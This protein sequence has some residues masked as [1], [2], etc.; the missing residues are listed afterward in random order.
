MAFV[1]GERISGSV[2]PSASLSSPASMIADSPSQWGYL[3]ED[4][5]AA[6]T[7]QAEAA[8]AVAKKRAV[9]NKPNVG[10][11]NDDEQPP[12]RDISSRPNGS[13]RPV[14]IADVTF[15]SPLHGYR[16]TAKAAHASSSDGPIVVDAGDSRSLYLRLLNDLTGGKSTALACS[17]GAV[18]TS[19]PSPFTPQFL[20]SHASPDH[21]LSQWL[22]TE[23]HRQRTE[24]HPLKLA[25]TDPAAYLPPPEPEYAPTAFGSSDQA[26]TAGGWAAVDEE[27]RDT[28]SDVEE[29][30]QRYWALEQAVIACIRLQCTPSSRVLA[31]DVLPF[32]LPLSQPCLWELCLRF[33]SHLGLQISRS[34]APAFLSST[35]ATASSGLSSR[36]LTSHWEAAF[37]EGSKG[38]L[39]PPPAGTGPA[40][41]DANSMGNC[42]SIAAGAVTPTNAPFLLRVLHRCITVFASNHSQQAVLRQALVQ[43]ETAVA[44]SVPSE[45]TIAAARQLSS[46]LAASQ[47]PMQADA[48]AATLSSALAKAWQAVT[49]PAANADKAA[50]TA[51]KLRACVNRLEPALLTMIR[52]SAVASDV[53]AMTVAASARKVLAS[54]AGAAMSVVTRVASDWVSRVQQ[55]RA[56]EASGSALLLPTAIDSAFASA[57]HA[58]SSDATS[59]SYSTPFFRM[60]SGDAACE[61]GSPIALALSACAA[62]LHS[63]TSS[64]SSSSSYSGCD[65]QPALQVLASSLRLFL[66]LTRALVVAQLRVAG[67]YTAADG[68]AGDYDDDEE[69]DAAAADLNHYLSRLQQ[70]SSLSPSGA[71][72]TG[73]SFSFARLV[74]RQSSA[75]AASTTDVTGNDSHA[76]VCP[77]SAP[78]CDALGLP[79]D[80]LAD[81][82]A[83]VI[84]TA[85]GCGRLIDQLMSCAELLCAFR[86]R[87]LQL[88]SCLYP[89]RSP[90]RLLRAARQVLLALFPGHPTAAIDILLPPPAP[91]T[92]GLQYNSYLNRSIFVG[93]TASS[94]G[95]SSDSVSSFSSSS[96]DLQGSALVSALSSHLGCDAP[97]SLQ[98]AQLTAALRSAGSQARISNNS[99]SSIWGGGGD[100]VTA[101]SMVERAAT[102]VL[103]GDHVSATSSLPRAPSLQPR[104]LPLPWRTLLRFRLFSGNPS[105]AIA[106]FLQGRSA[107]QWSQ[108][109][110]MD[111]L[112]RLRAYL[113]P[114]AILQLMRQR[115][116]AAGVVVLHTVPVP[117]AAASSS[118]SSAGIPP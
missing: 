85:T 112:L 20:P 117:V 10:G 49:A 6:T 8:A 7:V 43:L 40:A 38:P 67:A 71:T 12:R 41:S 102:A 86:I 96:I 103:L 82:N 77:L 113:P 61:A 51:D 75:A 15:Y 59:T 76:P 56:Q 36:C 84:D 22:A 18:Q 42:I 35:A 70:C 108:P 66:A 34:P 16:I 9:A 37:G 106:A 54:E 55:M 39:P 90:P 3:A 44:T 79:P 114:E 17:S 64:A 5:V 60:S 58:S 104:H 69:E 88:H 81:W 83:G 74:N 26:A 45:S 98:L 101:V 91:T 80:P 99:K 93:P 52:Q 32:L 30:E 95:G 47:Q 25:D 13:H 100:I 28:Q 111:L 27:E 29:D 97:L 118:R 62:A 31:S 21:P 53:S 92:A 4:E 11:D 23:L 68:T 65:P 107:C 57:L 48:F 46:L 73:G 63:Y 110:L 19:Q 78:A 14:D 50:S 94:E 115:A 24:Q 109:L 89:T 116:P 72:A 2:V 87:L 105:A 33:L 1:E